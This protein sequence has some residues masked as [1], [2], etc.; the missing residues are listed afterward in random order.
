MN[1]NHEIL[2]QMYFCQFFQSHYK[3][4]SN[5]PTLKPYSF[6]IKQSSSCSPKERTNEIL[7]IRI[8]SLFQVCGRGYISEQL[9]LCYPSSLPNNIPYSGTTL[10]LIIGAQLPR[11]TLRG[12]VLMSQFLMRTSILWAVN[13]DLFVYRTRPNLVSK[14]EYGWYL[15]IRHSLNIDLSDHKINSRYFRNI[16]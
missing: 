7:E 1:K 6:N 16:N 9:Y 12:L 3:L 11:W 4:S 13:I 15:F 2:V 5:T 8:S 10:V 14:C